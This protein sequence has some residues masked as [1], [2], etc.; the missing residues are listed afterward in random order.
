VVD[1]RLDD[2][3]LHQAV[4]EAIDDARHRRRPKW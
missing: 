3:E 1:R 4:L 2:P